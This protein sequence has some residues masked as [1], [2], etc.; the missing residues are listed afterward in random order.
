MKHLLQ[1][2]LVAMFTCLT[3]GVL[4]AQSSTAHRF[5]KVDGFL[6]DSG[7]VPADGTFAMTFSLWDDDL[8]DCG[9]PPAPNV[10]KFMAVAFG[11]SVVGLTA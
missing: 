7:G 9:P 3:S 11:S 5:I 2:V 6:K 1:T 4:F 8:L 10:L